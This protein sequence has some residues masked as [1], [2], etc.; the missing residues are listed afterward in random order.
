MGIWIS[1]LMSVFGDREA[2]I[3][4]LGLDNA[5]K[6]TILCEAHSLC[7]TCTAHTYKLYMH[8]SIDGPSLFNADRLQVGEVVST[9][10]SESYHSWCPYKSSSIHTR[11]TPC[12]SV[13]PYVVASKSCSSFAAIGFNVETVTYKNIKF[14]VWDL[15]G[16]TSIRP[17]WRCYYPNTQVCAMPN[18][19]CIIAE[20]TAHI[21]F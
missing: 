13:S 6:T 14:Q 20:L 18:I 12:S 3:L 5:G 11:W 19:S 10:P 1:R 16:Q 8:R 17:Y 21:V 9:I 7:S 4:V 15:G 2:R